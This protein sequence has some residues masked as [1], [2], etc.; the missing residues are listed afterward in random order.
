[1]DSNLNSTLLQLAIYVPLIAGIILFFGKSL[2]TSNS[3]AIAFVG[4]LVPAVI[5]IWLWLHFGDAPKNA[6]GYAYLS[7]F[8][9][10]ISK[11]L[12]ISLMLG[13]NGI[14][15]PMFLLSGLVGLAAGIHAIQ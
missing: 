12:G 7:N 6:A 4:F 10:G 1:M 13:L 8:D 14:S 11:S 2:G 3:K 5:S 9:T 15:C